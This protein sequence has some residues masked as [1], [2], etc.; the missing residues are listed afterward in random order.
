[1][2][3]VFFSSFITTNG[4][5]RPLNSSAS[6]SVV[7]VFGRDGGA[8]TGGA[9]FEGDISSVG[10]AFGG[11]S[12][13]NELV[14]LKSLASAG[15]RLMRASAHANTAMPI[16]PRR[17]SHIGKATWKIIYTILVF[18][19]SQSEAGRKETEEEGEGQSTEPK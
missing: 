12:L 9:G 5:P 2:G 17:S 10:D 11:P 6:L 18:T 15:H 16:R 13:Q 1:L 7:A 4:E 3:A 19:V 14:R 8:L